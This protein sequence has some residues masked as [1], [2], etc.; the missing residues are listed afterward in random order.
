MGEYTIN[1]P[2]SIT[3]REASRVISVSLVERPEVD[4]FG[5]GRRIS[6]LD[7]DRLVFP[8]T[9]RSRKSGDFFYPLGLGNR[10]KLQD[11]FV[12]EKI[13]RDERGIIPL[14]ISENEICCII[15]RRVDDRYKVNDNTKR[16]LRLEV[17]PSEI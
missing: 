7:A 2:C 10:K 9:I 12:D 11:F 13:P 14:L 8:L 5:D 17:K 6:C 4:A 1:G 15:G 3:I 16:V